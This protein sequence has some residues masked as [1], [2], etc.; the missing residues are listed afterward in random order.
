MLYFSRGREGGRE[1]GKEGKGR[2]RGIE[3]KRE[4]NQRSASDA[5]LNHLVFATGS[6]PEPGAARELQ[7]CPEL[8]LLEINNIGQL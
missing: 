3:G 7:G 6:L 1:G 8:G 5:F 2:E 4:A